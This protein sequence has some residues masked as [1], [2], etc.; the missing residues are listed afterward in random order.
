MRYGL[1]V[2][3]AALFCS[4]TAYAEVREN[5]YIGVGLEE[6]FNHFTIEAKN[7]T[8]GMEVS[9]SAHQTMSLPK[10]FLGYG[11]TYCNNVYVAGEI[12]AN[13]LQRSASLVRPGVT[14][15]STSFLDHLR[16]Q[17][18]LEAD[19]HV[20]YRLCY[21]WLAYITVGISFADM[22]IDQ[23]STGAVPRFSSRKN[24]VGGRFGVGINYP[25]TERIGIGLDY[26][27]ALYQRIAP[28]WSLYTIDFTEQV[29]TNY[30]TLSLFYSFW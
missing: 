14:V 8:S 1:S 4:G 12:G 22:E 23:P 13:F 9:S 30:L 26:C 29:H 27:Y 24:V 21:D 28:R 20:G 6:S 19:L 16:I 3:L 25:L 5:V 2:L 10:L 11:H 17:D 15:T 7:Y 18:Y